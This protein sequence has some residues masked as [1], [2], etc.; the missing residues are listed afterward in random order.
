MEDLTDLYERLYFHEIDAREQLNSRLQ[1]PLSLIVVLAGAFAY[2]LQTADHALTSFAAYLF[3]T[4]LILMGASFLVGT[5]SFVRAAWGH[6]YKFIPY[7]Q[8]IAAIVEQLKEYDVKYATTVADKLTA[9]YL[10]G[11]L[12]EG[13]T[14]NASNNDR[15]SAYLHWSNMGVVATSAFALLAFLAFVLGDLS[16][17]QSVMHV[18]LT[19][20]VDIRGISIPNKL[21]VVREED[22]VPTK[23]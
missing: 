1:L 13:A 11:Y 4:S 12:I 6:N 15:R 14:N 17:A 18:S 19:Q 3:R 2:L 21:F 10:R 9:E 23:Q 5:Y 7:A 16:R 20:P 8:Q 22:T